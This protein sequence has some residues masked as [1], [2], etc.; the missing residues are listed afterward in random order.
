MALVQRLLLAVIPALIV[1]GCAAPASES[2]TTT[3]G[4]LAALG[5]GTSGA[6]C[7]GEAH[8]CA[9]S[10]CCAGM[11]CTPNGSLG[12]LCRRPSPSSRGGGGGR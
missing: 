9:A 8:S 2:A 10:P 7:A 4:L 1:A 5:L 11:T 3:G 6:M 12:M